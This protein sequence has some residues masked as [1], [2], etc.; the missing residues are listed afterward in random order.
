MTSSTALVRRRSVRRGAVVLALTT[1]ALGSGVA[2]AAW[3]SS[4]TGS[5]TTKAG[6]A[7]APVVAA[8][9]VTTG[10][11]YP[12]GTGDAVVT[13]SNPN[14]YP[15]RVTSIAPNGA[16]TCGVTFSERFPGTQLAAKS[17]P[18]AITFSVTMSVDAPNSCQGAT[19]DV[20]VTVTIASG[21]GA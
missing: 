21:T 20:P 16:G 10:T 7:L 18:V 1:A 8:G 6:T 17:A 19:I 5:A 9:A 15:V 4:G 3:T 12:G 11:L 2:Y 14:P 13:V